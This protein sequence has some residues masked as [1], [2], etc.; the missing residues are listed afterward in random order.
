MTNAFDSRRSG[1]RTCCHLSRRGFIDGTTA[2]GLT[3]AFPA[4]WSA[5]EPIAT[6]IDTHHHFFPP[7]YQ[8]AWLE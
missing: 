7:A 6:L 1:T 3:T 5:A 2:L 4:K 8:K